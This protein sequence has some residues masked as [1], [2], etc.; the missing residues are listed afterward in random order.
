MMSVAADSETQKRRLEARFA[1]ESVFAL[2]TGA[3][4]L[5]RF[6]SARNREPGLLFLWRILFAL[7][8]PLVT[9]SQR[10]VLFTID[11]RATH[12]RTL[13]SFARS[14]GFCVIWVCISPSSICQSS[15]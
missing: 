2:K 10:T 3:S 11:L 1:A 6:V 9:C 7:H 14:I 5:V 13:L 12:A 8:P 4:P 15:L